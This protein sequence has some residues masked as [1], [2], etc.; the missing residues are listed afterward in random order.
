MIKEKRR[1]TRKSRKDG[2]RE[3]TDAVAV[4]RRSLFAGLAPAA[5]R[6]AIAAWK[7]TCGD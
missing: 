6:Y 1:W 4:K 3:S 2:K 5:F 7:R